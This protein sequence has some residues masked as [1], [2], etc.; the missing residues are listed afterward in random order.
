MKLSKLAVIPAPVLAASAF[1]FAPGASASSACHSSSG[2][3]D[4]HCTPGAVNP[5]VTQKNIHSTICKKGWTA[6]IRPR[7]SYT[8]ALKG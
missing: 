2:L 7:E 5:A 8:E 3:P 6:T 4:R 1:S